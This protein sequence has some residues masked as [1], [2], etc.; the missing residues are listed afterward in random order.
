MGGVLN[1]LACYWFWFWANHWNCCWLV[2]RLISLGTAR[3]MLANK[4]RCY[5]KFIVWHLCN[6]IAVNSICSFKHIRILVFLMYTLNSKANSGWPVRQFWGMKNV[7]FQS[8]VLS[9]H[10]LITITSTHSVWCKISH[11][12]LKCF[13]GN[14][15][16]T[17]FVDMLVLRPVING[18]IS[19]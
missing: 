12:I 16:Q 3:F 14:S 2:T 10:G 4:E 6:W 19:L 7:L 15:I 13:I 11:V 9:Q 17:W 5:Q 1:S 8:P 18:H